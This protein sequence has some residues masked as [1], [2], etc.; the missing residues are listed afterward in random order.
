MTVLPAI[1]AVI[2]YRDSLSGRASTVAAIA[3]TNSAVQEAILGSMSQAQWLAL[4]EP[5]IVPVW[6]AGVVAFAMR[7]LWSARHVAR[8][9]R[10]GEP[11]GSSLVEAVERLASR[12]NLGRGVRVVISRFADTPSTIGWLKPVIV[13]PVSSLLNISSQQLEAILAHELAHI[14]RHDYLFNM[15]Q[16]LAET[17][18]FYHPAIWWVSSR[19]R[20]ERE[21]C[22]DDLA[23]ELCGDAIGYARA[24]TT[25]ERL[26]VGAP[27]L[28]LS[29]SGGSL[30]YR[31]RRL[32]GAADEQGPS[33]LPG[34]LAIFVVLVCVALNTP[35]SKIQ[36]QSPAP[37]VVSRDSIWV[38]SVKFGT[39]SLKVRGLGVLISPTTAELKIAETQAAEV[40][41]A[42]NAMLE[43][44][45]GVTATGKV[46]TVGNFAANGTIKVSVELRSAMPEF[47]N[48]TVDGI[49]DIKTLK[50]VVY[51]GRPVFGRPNSEDHLFKL[52]PDG[53]HANRVKVRY[54][55]SSVNTIQIVDGLQL[56][57]R[58]ILSDMSKYDRV[59]RVQLK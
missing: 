29:S 5:W 59:D 18:F 3:V 49:V 15:L 42:Q 12:M 45:Q 25:L 34:L 53:L 40:A 58:V 4:I 19:I 16:V 23:V 33:R 11:G 38:D 35:W 47:V 21:L 27:E 55:L 30:L 41:V 1:T 7:L 48:K 24:L 32:T 20:H 57:D 8:L 9:R 51:V 6:L 50:D 31:I 54:G 14:R 28:A 36:A 44:R 56:G 10:E 17:L 2:A 13:L 22:C 46:S 37:V 39:M 52:D 43:F 26:R